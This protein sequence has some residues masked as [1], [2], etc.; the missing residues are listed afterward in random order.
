MLCVFLCQSFAVFHDF[1]LEVSKGSL[2]AISI[3]WMMARE[4]L[5]NCC[6]CHACKNA[7]VRS[8][9]QSFK[10]RSGRS[11]R[12]T[13]YY[14]HYSRYFRATGCTMYGVCVE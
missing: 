2:F 14:N 5:A 11:Y 12:R 10:V 13:K 8:F 6:Q 4:T 9:G 7:L 3:L 1:S